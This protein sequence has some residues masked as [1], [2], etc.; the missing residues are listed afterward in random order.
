[1]NAGNGV[2]AMVSD[3]DIVTPSRSSGGGGWSRFRTETVYGLG[4]DAR[5]PVALGKLYATKGRP[6]GHPVI[7]HLADVSQLAQWARELPLQRRGCG[8]IWPGR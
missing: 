8:K 5:N 1:M 6:A 2:P 4:A 3:P 7:V